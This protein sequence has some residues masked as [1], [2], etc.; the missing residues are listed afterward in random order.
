MDCFQIRDF[1]DK[2]KKAGHKTSH[3]YLLKFA[4]ELGCRLEERETAGRFK[5]SSIIPELLPQFSACSGRYQLARF[6]ELGKIPLAQIGDRELDRLL[7][8]IGIRSQSP[9][10]EPAR[11][12]GLPDDSMRYAKSGCQQAE[13]FDP[14]RGLNF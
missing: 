10:D 3:Q 5:R 2:Y 4:R 1:P 6:V 12:I 7:I 8:Q 9:V 13:F 11:H 14:L